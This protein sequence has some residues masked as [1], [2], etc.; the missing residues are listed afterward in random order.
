MNG[1]HR[2][3]RELAATWWPALAAGLLSTAAFVWL[4]QTPIIRALGL[5]L[6]VLGVTMTL[7]R[8]GGGLAIIGSLALAFS[9]AFWSQ[10]GGGAQ[11][12]ATLI[13]IILGLAVAGAFLLWLAGKRPELGVAAGMVLFVLL[14]WGLTGTP[15]SLRLTTLLTAW[16]L[17]L[18]VDALMIANPRPDAQASAPPG[19]RHTLGLLL[20]FALGVLNDPLF[21]LMTP[22]LALGLLMLKTRLPVWYWAALAGVLVI[23]LRGAALVYLDSDWWLFPARQAVEQGIQVPFVMADGWREGTRW[24]YV[25]DIIVRQFTA[26]GVL[27]GVL[28]L[29]RLA[30]WFPPVGEATMLAYA[31]YAL[32]GLTY[33]GK[34]SS[35][36]LLPLLMIQII[37]MTYAVYAFG[38]WLQK[39]S[40][41]SRL[42]WLAPA[43]FALLPLVLLLRITGG[44]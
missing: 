27:L 22:A 41:P 13:L 2:I 9:P 14:F 44:R 20:L 32:F 18:L 26:A 15:R 23:G 8:F 19:M 31:A 4:G 25:I 39:S 40:R 3:N 17:Y 37:W 1:L 34:D 6:A 24:V 10:T 28:G 11:P 12:L 30:R 5:A 29:S 21:I 16:T 38:Q 7:R 42:H 36:L 43:A 35:V 33:F